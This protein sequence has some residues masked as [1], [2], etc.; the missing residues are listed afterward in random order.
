VIGKAGT[1]LGR[2]DEKVK[3][4]A[5]KTPASMGMSVSD[6]ARILLA[7][8]AAEGALPLHVKISNTTTAE[9]MQAADDLSALCLV[10]RDTARRRTACWPDCL[11]QL[12]PAGES[13][14]SSGLGNA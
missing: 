9:A 4:R 14:A 3:R 5:A 13:C 7:R 10:E 1:F 12:H 11:G 6:A 2:V 8:A